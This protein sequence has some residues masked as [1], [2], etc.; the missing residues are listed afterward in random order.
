LRE[1]TEKHIQWNRRA[2]GTISALYL[3][4]FMLFEIYSAAAT[5]LDKNPRFPGWEHPLGWVL[6]VLPCVL[7]ASL[8]L[9]H[10]SRPKLGFLLVAGNL[11]LYASFMIFESVAFGGTP[12]SP[13]AIWE[14]GGIWAVLFLAAVL[15]AR[16]L[17]IKTQ[18][19]N[20]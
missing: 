16:F 10:G 15:A 8:F 6:F 18:A 13:W 1:S 11:C 12:A 14:V 5:A 9:L 20:S 19:R 17:E 4:I 7:L 3:L 2:G